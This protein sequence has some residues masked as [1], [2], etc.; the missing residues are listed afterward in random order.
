MKRIKKIKNSIFAIPAALAAIAVK[1]N[2]AATI[3]IIKKTIV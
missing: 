2:N 3:A 1:P